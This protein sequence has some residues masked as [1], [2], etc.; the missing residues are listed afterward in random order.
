MEKEVSSVSVIQFSDMWRVLV[1]RIPM[2][3]MRYMDI[4]IYKDRYGD[5][6]V[7]LYVAFVL[8][9]AL[10]CMFLGHGLFI[11]AGMARN[12]KSLHVMSYHGNSA[13]MTMKIKTL[14]SLAIGLLACL[15]FSLLVRLLLNYFYYSAIRVFRKPALLPKT[16]GR[17]LKTET[18]I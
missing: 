9:D 6:Y 13:G 4:Y 11:T 7:Y 8:S 3:A 12:I 5:P 18:I 16:R 15:P 17:S 10:T 1:R 2:Y 14:H